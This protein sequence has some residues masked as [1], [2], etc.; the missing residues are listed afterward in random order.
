MRLSEILSFVTVVILNGNFS[1]LNHFPM[2]L[3]NSGLYFP[4]T[5][6][7]SKTCDFRTPSCLIVK[8]VPTFLRIFVLKPVSSKVSLSAALNGL[9]PFSIPP[10]GVTQIG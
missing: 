10:P 2:F 8:Y 6:L 7:A 5:Y 4:D 9:S 1:T 3:G